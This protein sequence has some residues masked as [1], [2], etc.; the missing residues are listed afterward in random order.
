MLKGEDIRP[1]FIVQ[2]EGDKAL[3]GKFYKIIRSEASQY[4]TG[5]TTGAKEFSTVATTLE[6]DYKQIDRLEPSKTQLAYYDWYVKDGCIYQ[7]KLKAGTIRFGPQ[8]EPNVGFIDNELSGEVYP[9]SMFG[10][11][12]YNDWFPAINAQNVTPYTLTPQVFFIG[13]KFDIE[14]VDAQE[15]VRIRQTG[16]YSII[17]L[18]GVNSS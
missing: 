14:E 5:K 17:I 9:N 11:W 4:T 8:Q 3:K 12:L 2:V 13:W 7:M 10:I 1:G 15:M 6:S 18:G 16:K